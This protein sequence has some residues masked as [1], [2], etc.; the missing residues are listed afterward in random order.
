M[1][2]DDTTK[3]IEGLEP[4]KLFRTVLGEPSGDPQAAERAA[5]E[6]RRVRAKSEATAFTGSIWA[7]MV[8]SSPTTFWA[9]SWLSQKSAAPIRS[10]SS[11]S[12]LTLES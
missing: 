6:E 7:L 1:A 9:L 5:E 8:L 12:L 4:A 2:D 11:L 10:S 3:G